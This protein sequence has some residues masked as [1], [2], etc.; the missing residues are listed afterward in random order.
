VAG[1]PEQER[2]DAIVKAFHR[3]PGQEVERFGLDLDRPVQA[4]T[5]EAEQLFDAWKLRQAELKEAMKTILQP[6]E[7]M[8]NLTRTL[9]GTAPRAVA[10]EA[11]DVGGA[12]S[13]T[14]PARALD[15]NEQVYILKQLESL[16]DDVD[17]ARDFHT[18]GAWPTLLSFLRPEHPSA[19]RA[20]AAWAVGTAVKNTYDYQL[21]VLESLPAVASAEGGDAVA[22]STVTALEQLVHLLATP[23]GVENFEVQKRALYALSAA[24][25]GNV[26]VQAAA[27][28]VLSADGAAVLYLQHLRSLTELGTGLPAEV[29]RK[30]WASAA[31]LLEERAF[32]HKEL[33]AEVQRAQQRRALA[34]NGSDADAQADDVAAMDAESAVLALQAMPM[35]GDA[36]VSAQWLQAASKAGTEL[37]RSLL[38]AQTG[39]GTD[40][41]AEVAEHSADTVS[42]HAALRSVLAFCKEVLTD[43]PHLYGAQ[44]GEQWSAQL[45]VL[46]RTVT[47]DFERESG[48]FDALTTAGDELAAILG[49]LDQGANSAVF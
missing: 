32:I 8:A 4:G 28:R 44:G 6:A 7:H 29:Q 19:V 1:V 25:R 34:L 11:V 10:E 39:R 47:A 3:L 38:V 12:V 23:A 43:S 14:E 21:W 15:A 46:V 17:N 36:L 2:I 37:A 18:I 13:T 48:M 49:L 5:P 16:L 27:L 30:V 22:P 24:M 31:D 45:Q 33:S 40:A 42:E 41:S 9:N 20:A 26:D 35:L